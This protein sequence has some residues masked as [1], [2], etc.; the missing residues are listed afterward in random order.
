MDSAR[1]MGA[2]SGPKTPPVAALAAATL[3]FL[4]AA[5]AQD[6]EVKIDCAAKPH[7]EGGNDRDLA[8]RGRHPTYRC[9]VGA[10]IQVDGARHRRQL[11]IHLHRTGQLRLFLLDA[12]AHERKDRGRAWDPRGESPCTRTAWWGRE[13]SNRQPDGYQPQRASSESGAHK[14]GIEDGRR[15]DWHSAANRTRAGTAGTG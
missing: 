11:F 4:D 14:H 12:S 13:D 5:A 6:A 7:R 3:L 9:L 8:Q 2:W 10:S 15:K 1:M